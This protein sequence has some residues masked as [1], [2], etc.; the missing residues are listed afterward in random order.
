MASFHHASGSGEEGVKTDGLW[1]QPIIYII[2]RAGGG[3]QGAAMQRA[4]YYPCKRAYGM[5]SQCRPNECLFRVWETP[6]GQD[7]R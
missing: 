7:F 2:W 1:L 4:L 6:G 3:W 5:G